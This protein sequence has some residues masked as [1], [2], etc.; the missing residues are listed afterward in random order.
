[1]IRLGFITPLA[2]IHVSIQHSVSALAHRV[3][4]SATRYKNLRIDPRYGTGSGSDLAPR[5]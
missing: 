3:E 1:M 2:I 4:F 5:K